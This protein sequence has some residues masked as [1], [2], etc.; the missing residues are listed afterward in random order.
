MNNER[1]TSG[2]SIGGGMGSIA[3]SSSVSPWNMVEDIP[4][5]TAGDIAEGE[6]EGI[7]NAMEQ[8]VQGMVDRFVTSLEE[9]NWKDSGYYISDVY[10]CNSEERANALARR[11]EERA[12]TFRRGFIGIAIH[13][14]HVHTIHSCSYANKSCRCLFKNFPEAKEDLRRHIRKPRA[15]ET[16]KRRDWQ[17]I[18][19][20][21]STKGRRTTFFKVHG[22]DKRVPIEISALSN[23]GLPGENGGG[24]HTSLEDCYD[25]LQHDTESR[26]SDIPETPT[27][28]RKRYRRNIVQPGGARGISGVVGII[29]DLLSEYAICPLSEIVYVNDYLTNHE[30]ACKRLDCKEVKDAIDT[31][32]SVINTWDREEFQKF[33]NNENVKKIW[34]ARSLSLFDNYYMSYDESIDIVFKLLSFQMEANINVFVRDLLN[35]LESRVSKLNCFV[36]VSAP[37]AG[38][39]FLFDGIRDYYLNSGQMNNPNKYNQF[40]YQD[41]H[42]RRII[43]W[44]EPNYEPRETEH[45]KMLFAGDNLSANV[46]CKPQANVKRTPVIVLTNNR[47]HFLNQHAFNDRLVHY[48]WK[49]APFLKECNKKPRPDAIMN[50]LYSLDI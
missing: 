29:L 47:P 44:N 49:P 27:H 50:L 15:V 39:N 31:R 43:I 13:N 30:I 42:N 20:Y 6:I 8:D 14:D 45:L 3:G 38:K 16:F 37:S 33:Y 32:A 12:G 34:S 24:P 11:L 35:V 21:F 17:N 25:P 1:N 19:K 23:I 28:S 5:G 10:A 9:E 22:T 36:V 7:I 40:A 48:T 26:G 46:K 18:I 4:V 41:C 2:A